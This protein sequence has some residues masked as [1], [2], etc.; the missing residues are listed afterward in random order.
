MESSI[1]PESVEVSTESTPWAVI[2]SD[3][4]KVMHSDLFEYPKEVY[5]QMGTARLK[6]AKFLFVQGNPEE[7]HREFF[8]AGNQFLERGDFIPAVETYLRAYDVSDKPGDEQRQLLE[9]LTQALFL[10]AHGEDA[11]PFLEGIVEKYPDWGIPK[12]TLARALLDTERHQESLHWIEDVLRNNPDNIYALAVQAEY[13]IVHNDLDR[14]HELIEEL[15]GRKG[16]PTWLVDH[17]NKLN[18]RF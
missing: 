7:A 9:S 15:L 13:H 5:T 11:I 4:G 3:C 2:C 18:R 1:P 16:L 12:I 10:G 6:Q 14:G 8:I 17:L